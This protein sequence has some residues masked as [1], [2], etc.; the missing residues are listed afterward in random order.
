MRTLGERA[1]GKEMPSDL[2]IMRP[3]N[4]DIQINKR[5]IYYGHYKINLDLL[6]LS[7][8]FK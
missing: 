3:L 2:A 4:T 7:T 6:K 8:I 5:P 1:N